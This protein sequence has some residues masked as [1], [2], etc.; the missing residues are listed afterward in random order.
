MNYK[1]KSGLKIISNNRKAKFNY[2]FKEF[3]EAGI[4]LNGSEVKSL[5]EGKANISESYAFDENGEIFLSTCVDCPSIDHVFHFKSVK[6]I[7]DMIVSSG[8]KIIDKLVLPVED[9]P[10]DEIIKRKITINY[11]ALLKKK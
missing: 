3:F 1:T 4:V 7:D 10:M 8:F 5:R 9:K 2:F 11:C 6:E